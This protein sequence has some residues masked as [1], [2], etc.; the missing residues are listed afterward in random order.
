LFEQIEARRAAAQKQ[1]PPKPA[2]PPPARK[3]SPPKPAAVQKVAPPPEKAPAQ[4]VPDGLRENLRDCGFSEANI[5]AALDHGL[6]DF[7][8]CCDYITALMEGRKPPSTLTALQEQLFSEL[9]DTFDPE[10]LHSAFA[11]THSEDRDTI[12]Q[13]ICQR[14]EMENA[15]VPDV[16][17]EMLWSEVDWIIAGRPDDRMPIGIAPLGKTRVTHVIVETDE[18]KAEKQA[19]EKQ[20]KE[21]AALAAMISVRRGINTKEHTEAPPASKGAP[22]GPFQIKFALQER[23]LMEKFEEG[24]TVGE[25]FA[26]LREKG[27]DNVKLVLSGQVAVTIAPEDAEKK[28]ADCVPDR[29]FACRTVPV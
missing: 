4:K 7:N 28:L 5:D 24:V 13:W 19:L 15:T 2:P 10:D 9:V 1:A 26:R 11:Q 6:R 27:V 22:R 18:L 20:R 23:S 3:V 29:R 12:I 16:T 14:Q 21:R 8:Q 25:V 17:D